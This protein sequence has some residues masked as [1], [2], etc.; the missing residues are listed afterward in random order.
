MAI[1]DADLVVGL[2][3]EEQ[4]GDHGDSLLPCDASRYIL[5]LQQLV[6]L[7]QGLQLPELGTRI[8][9]LPGQLL[10][11]PWQRFW[12][13]QTLTLHLKWHQIEWW[14]LLK[15]MLSLESVVQA[16]WET[17]VGSHQGIRCQNIFSLKAPSRV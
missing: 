4:W 7:C 5:L 3:V 10:W 9:Q 16:T 6:Y 1:W 8:C 12:R 11:I 15:E 13:H 14:L 2:D 17:G